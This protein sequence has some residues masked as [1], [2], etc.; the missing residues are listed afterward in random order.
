M[1]SVHSWMLK[2]DKALHRPVALRTSFA[3]SVD[4]KEGNCIK[5]RFVEVQMWCF[6]GCPQCAVTLVSWLIVYSYFAVRQKKEWRGKQTQQHQPQ[7]WRCPRLIPSMSPW[8]LPG[9]LQDTSPIG[10]KVR[11][12]LNGQRKICLKMRH[13]TAKK[14]RGANFLNSS[15]TA[16]RSWRTYTPKNM[17]YVSLHL[18]LYINML[19]LSH[20]ISISL[21][22]PRCICLS[23]FYHLLYCIITFW[24]TN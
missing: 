3:S 19:N 7:C 11:D 13:S 16:T 24:S 12:K 8:V 14:I 4:K 21:Q 18:Y 2:A 22:V 5:K 20:C 10:G 15:N 6:N 17:R 1:E 23:S 9:C